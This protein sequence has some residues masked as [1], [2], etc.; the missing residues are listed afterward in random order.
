MIEVADRVDTSRPGVDQGTETETATEIETT[1]E[2]GENIHS[3][4]HMSR[5]VVGPSA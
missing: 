1:T 5:S 3:T 4:R 2:T